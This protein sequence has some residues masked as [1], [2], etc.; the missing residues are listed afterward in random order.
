MYLRTHVRDV[1]KNWTKNGYQRSNTKLIG[2]RRETGLKRTS[3]GVHGLIGGSRSEVY[4]RN[5]GAHRASKY[6]RQKGTTNRNE[7]SVQFIQRR[8]EKERRGEGREYANK[9]SMTLQAKG[10]STSNESFKFLFFF[11]ENEIQKKI[12]KMGDSL[13]ALDFIWIA[14]NFSIKNKF[15]ERYYGNVKYQR[16]GI[17]IKCWN[18]TRYIWTRKKREE[19]RDM[20]H[21][22]DRIGKKWGVWCGANRYG[23]VRVYE[24][25]KSSLSFCCSDTPLLGRGQAGE[26]SMS[27]D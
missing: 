12:K 14:M 1:Q 6:D 20:D 22:S 23:W 3:V 17:M 25:Y 9:G 2:G 21:I 4:Y 8:K 26:S 19:K 24:R 13:G 7:K 5:E 15:Y 27:P 16:W 10:W 18:K 11:Q